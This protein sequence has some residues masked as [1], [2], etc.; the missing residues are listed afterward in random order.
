MLTQPQLVVSA[1]CLRRADF[2]SRVEAAAE[3]GFSGVGLRVSDYVSAINREGLSRRDLGHILKASG[4]EIYEVEAA[5]DWTDKASSE[6]LE[7][8]D[9]LK[10]MREDL[11]FRQFNAFIFHPARRET[12]LEGYQG[13]CDA[14]TEIPVGLEHIGYGPVVT[15][16]QA[17]R[18]V[19]ESDRVNAKV[20]LDAWHFHRTDSRMSDL[21]SL[22]PAEVC[23]IQ[24]SDTH[25]SPGEDVAHEAR[26][27]RALPENGT[28]DLT[29][30]LGTILDLG[31]RVPISIE[32]VNDVFDHMPPRAAALRQFD[33]LTRLIASAATSRVDAEPLS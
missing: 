9:T 8:L 4:V 18:L 21:Q 19:R 30:W 16:N 6:N 25:P 13:L 29:R 11:E 22:S 17:I 23:S 7:Y 14:L 31:V 20:I 15:L 1:N 5:W 26:H 10:R 2:V 32:V 12:I 24:I 28:S 27:E 33:S 3:A